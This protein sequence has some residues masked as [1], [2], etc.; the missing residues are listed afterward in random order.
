MTNF[1]NNYNNKQSSCYFLDIRNS[2][3]I[4]RTI[5][6]ATDKTLTHTDKRINAHSEFMSDLHNFLIKKLK[7]L[8]LNNF[9]FSNTG[10]GHTCLLWNKTHAW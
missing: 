8:G 3:N 6:L 7:E 1:T 4:I 2:T 10:D 5:S 9:Y